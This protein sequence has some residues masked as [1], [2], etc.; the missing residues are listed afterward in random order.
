MK[1]MKFSHVS[2]V[3]GLVLGMMA[4]WAEATPI[5]VSGDLVTGGWTGCYKS[6]IYIAATS[7]SCDPC[8]GVIISHCYE[9]DQYCLGNTLTVVKVTGGAGYTPHSAGSSRSSGTA[10]TRCRR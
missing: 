8:Q 7:S 4:L 9:Y 2:L 5:G 3:I 10:C 6:G 1:W